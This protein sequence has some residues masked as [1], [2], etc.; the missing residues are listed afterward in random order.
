MVSKLHKYEK[1]H[2]EQWALADMEIKDLVGALPNLCE[3]V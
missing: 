3:D 1:L 2:P